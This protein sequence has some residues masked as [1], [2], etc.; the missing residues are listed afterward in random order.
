MEIL[1]TII[2]MLLYAI[3]CYALGYHRGAE[4]MR[5]SYDEGWLDAEKALKEKYVMYDRD[6]MINQLW[7]EEQEKQILNEIEELFEDN[8]I[9]DGG[10]Y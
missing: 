7:R 8:D 2:G 9:I 10:C 5:Y 1:W 4:T 6:E 3:A